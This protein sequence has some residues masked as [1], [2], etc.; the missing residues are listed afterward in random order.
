MKGAWEAP[1][2]RFSYLF[3]ARL[4]RIVGTNLLSVLLA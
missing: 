3:A 4:K 1:F 2:G